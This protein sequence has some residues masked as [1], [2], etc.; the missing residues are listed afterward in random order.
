MD[1]ETKF[2]LRAFVDTLARFLFTAGFMY[3]MSL[4]Y[5]ASHR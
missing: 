4:L 5:H 3:L 2:Y 1:A